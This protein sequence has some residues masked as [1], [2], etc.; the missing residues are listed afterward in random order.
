M[1]IIGTIL[2]RRKHLAQAITELL[3][4]LKS[5]QLHKETNINT[6]QPMGKELTI[7]SWGNNWH[8]LGKDGENINMLT[9]G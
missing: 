8:Y 1:G 6:W 4:Y 2:L 5:M 7:V 9:N 3:N